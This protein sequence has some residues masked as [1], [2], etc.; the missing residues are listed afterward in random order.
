MKDFM[1]VTSENLVYCT[2]DCTIP[3]I[4]KKLLENWTD[5]VLIADGKSKVLGIVTDGI[6][7]NLISKRDPKIYDYKAKDI[8]DKNLKIIEVKKGFNFIDKMRNEIDKTPVKR[9]I[10]KK[11]GEIIGLIQKKIYEKIKRHARTFNVEFKT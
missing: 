5:T 6:I 8:M 7:W 9:L 11:E 3:I 4:A 1:Y 2:P 10:V